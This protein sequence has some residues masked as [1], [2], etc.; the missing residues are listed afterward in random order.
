MTA[1]STL[2]S[3]AD[4]TTAAPARYAKQL[5]SHLSRKVAFTTDGDTST[6]RLG[7]ATGQVV[8]GDG[9]LVLLASGPDQEAVA[10]VE[11]VLGGHLERF[12]ARDGLTVD[13]TRG[14]PEATP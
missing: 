9:V 1:T 2:H 11:D 7:E 14:T 8:V 3:R 10:Q 4:V 5:V 6:V 13:W 12:G